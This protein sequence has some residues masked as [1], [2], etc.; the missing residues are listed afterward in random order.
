M[1]RAAKLLLVPL[2]LLQIL[3]FTFVAHHRFIDRDEGF[4]LLASRLVL[5]H[6][7]P[8]LD[9][10][11][12]QAPLLPYVYAIWM[13]VTTVSWTSAKLFSVLLTVLLG[14]LLYEHVCHETRNW[15]AGVS[16]AVIFAANTLVFA[17]FPMVKTYSLAG[18]LLF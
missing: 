4:Y 1:T 11:Y 10:F 16:A 2:S 9:F 17:Y 14:T 12:T 5:T 18:L 15:L 3:F 8:Y 13:K 6:K 7:K